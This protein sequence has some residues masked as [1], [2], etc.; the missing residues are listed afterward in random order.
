MGTA[1]ACGSPRHPM[2]YPLLVRS[3]EHGP[4][5]QP[6]SQINPVDFTNISAWSSTSGI[7]DPATPR[8][9]QRPSRTNNTTRD[10]T[11]RMWTSVPS[12]H[13]RP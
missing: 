1:T 7:L 8:K 3:D 5:D 6:P 12:C 11:W 13:A 9:K 10:G 2:S 4:G